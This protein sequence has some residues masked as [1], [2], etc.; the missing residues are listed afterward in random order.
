MIFISI[1]DIALLIYFLY[2]IPYGLS[3]ET[4]LGKEDLFPNLT[5]V[6]SL[7]LFSYL[8]LLM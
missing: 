2:I 5:I 3:T 7:Y 6:A 8:S 4:G 1:S